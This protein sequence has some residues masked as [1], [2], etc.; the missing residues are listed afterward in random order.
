MRPLP[1]TRTSPKARFR[2][3]IRL[4]DD[5]AVFKVRQEGRRPGSRAVGLSKLNS[6]Q[7]PAT[8]SRPAR[9]RALSAGALG[10]T[11]RSV[12]VRNL[13]EGNTRAVLRSWSR[14]GAPVL[15]LP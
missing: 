14:A 1:R 12:D 5:C 8:W 9:E 7:A 10:A 3:G 2:R 11:S 15:E 6:M 4:L 13:V